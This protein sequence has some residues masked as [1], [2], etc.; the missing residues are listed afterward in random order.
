M[1]FKPDISDFLNV[2]EDVKCRWSMHKNK[3]WGTLMSEWPFR[4]FDSP[5]ITKICK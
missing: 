5:N 1:L 4:Y 2:L 3:V